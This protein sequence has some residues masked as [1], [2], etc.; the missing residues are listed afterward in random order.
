MRD[1]IP[2]K[3]HGG[4]PV[5]ERIEENPLASQTLSNGGSQEAVVLLR[6]LSESE[7]S[8]ED[9]RAEDGGPSRGLKQSDGNR[10]LVQHDSR[11]LEDAGVSPV[12]VGPG[13][14]WVNLFRLG[15]LDNTPNG[16][17][18]S[19]KQINGG[20]SNETPVTAVS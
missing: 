5:R 18:D 17:R 2:R 10:T 19:E 15:V 1:P 9:K 14:P 6:L 20:Q 16:Q 13:D 4:E 7:E 8:E 3:F 12:G 11:E